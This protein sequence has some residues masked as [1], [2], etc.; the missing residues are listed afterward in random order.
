MVCPAG[1]I[2][3]DGFTAKISQKKIK[4]QLLLGLYPLTLFLRSHHGR[5]ASP[6]RR[7]I[8]PS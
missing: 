4:I 5:L 1:E 8:T 2:L 7:I 3:A 6:A